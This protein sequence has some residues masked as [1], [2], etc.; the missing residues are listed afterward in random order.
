[1]P[2]IKKIIN[3]EYI[4][5]TSYSLE[6]R[7]NG[8]VKLTFNPDEV[9]TPGSTI[10]AEEIN[11]IQKNGVYSCTLT[12][13]VV[14]QKEI[15]TADL[16][17]FEEFGKFEIIL[18]CNFLDTNTTQTPSLR[19][20]NTEYQIKNVTPNK[21]RG[22]VLIKIRDN[23]AYPLNL[24]SEEIENNNKIGL[25]LLGALNLK[26]WLVT[27]YTSLMNNIKEALD[28][29]I[30]T[31][32][33]HGG[34]AG[35]G[36]T[37]FNLIE[38][39]K[40]SLTS[41]IN[42]KENSFSKNG[43]FNKNF[44]TELGTVLE[45][46][47]LAETLGLEYGGIV[48]NNNAK[49]AGKAYYCTSNKAIYKCTQNNS[50]NYIDANYFEG[51]SNDKL[52]GKLQNLSNIRYNIISSE[53]PSTG[54]KAQLRLARIGNIIIFKFDTYSTIIKRGDIIFKFPVGFRPASPYQ[55]FDGDA[56]GVSMNE[57]GSSYGGY[58]IDNTG[59]RARTDINMGS[60]S[61]GSYLTLDVY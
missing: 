38:T 43:A 1:M 9:I 20:E 8:K 23:K 33:N 59:I 18:Q 54:A 42:G 14:G 22:E 41:L 57:H 29:K 12:R 13:T 37:L 4:E 7:P 58:R 48:N 3:G 51:L 45:G 36:Q 35:T 11:E 28:T 49:T 44:G 26:N 34:Y 25:S 30:G 61:S 16:T 50:L 39:S 27:S 15:Y 6:Q 55:I 10:G 31:K 46:A 56:G 32:L 60:L 47:K 24:L 53:L 19:I 17:G 5:G 52:L 2:K 40:N 21:L